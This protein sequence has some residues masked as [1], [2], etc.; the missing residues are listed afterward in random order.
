MPRAAKITL[1]GLLALLA[2]AY[3]VFVLL[4]F[5]DFNR[6]EGSVVDSYTDYTVI[7]TIVGTDRSITLGPGGQR[8]M[9]EEDEGCVG[10]GL[11]VSD[12]DGNVLATFDRGPCD[13]NILVIGAN[14]G[15]GFEYRGHSETVWP[16]IHP[17]P[18]P[19]PSTTT[20]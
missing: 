1:A 13:G 4:H 7:V 6:Q 12:T 8:Q 3:A 17:T 14:G 20:Q 11:V 16:T 5:V 2:A 18:D 15:I 19:S 10:D 9:T